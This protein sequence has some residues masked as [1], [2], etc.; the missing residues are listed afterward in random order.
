M[1]FFRRV[2]TVLI[3]MTIAVTLI[4]CAGTKKQTYSG[5]LES[6]PKFDKGPGSIDQRYLKPGVDFSKYKKVMLDEVVFFFNTDS[7][8]KGIHPT[9]IK[10]LSDTFNE[11]YVKEL[12]DRLTDTP[13]PDVCRMR[14]AITD[15]VP[16]RPVTGTMTT[17]IP[18]GLA[19]S[20]VE[21][22]VTG[23]YMGIGSASAEVEMLDSMTNERIAAGV[24][25]YSGG[26]LDVGKM[27]PAKAAFE[28]WAKMLHAFFQ[29]WWN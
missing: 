27:S 19:A 26:K 18:V 3:F 13:G 17:I 2:L 7:D 25:K 24:D 20:V 23:D 1:N 8:Y 5:F 15:L 9:E 10:K 21:K 4:G 14:L 11:V 28:Y 22:G 16:S 12:G 29:D 6:Y